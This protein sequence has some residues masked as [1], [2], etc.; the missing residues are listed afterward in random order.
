M[1]VTAKRFDE[2]FYAFR[3]KIKELERRVGSV[4]TTGFDDAPTM[5][6]RFKVR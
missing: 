6:G 4:L 1:D 3:N 5:T 2:D